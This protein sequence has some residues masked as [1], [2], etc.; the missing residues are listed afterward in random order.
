MFKEMYADYLEVNAEVMVAFFDVCVVVEMPKKKKTRSGSYGL[1]ALRS[2]TLSTLLQPCPKP[3][4]LKE[5]CRCLFAM[6]PNQLTA[7]KE[8]DGS[9]EAVPR[10]AVTLIVSYDCAGRGETK[11]KHHRPITV[12]RCTR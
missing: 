11:K 10:G 8:K 1:T 4:G 12:V 5:A 3:P 7:S 6:V 2:M 9:Q